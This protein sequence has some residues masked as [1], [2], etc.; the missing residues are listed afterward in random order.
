MSINPEEI[1][2]TPEQQEQLA[3]V[4][5]QSG[6]PWQEL[7]A[8]VIGAIPEPSNGRW[9]SISVD[10]SALICAIAASIL[11]CP[12]SRSACESAHGGSKAEKV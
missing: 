3:R 6:Q 5:E 1:R 10:A 11:T 4:A 7:L 9:P 8:R 12:A 2:L